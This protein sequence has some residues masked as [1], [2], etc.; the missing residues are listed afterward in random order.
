MNNKN[1]FK[2]LIV[3]Q[4]SIVLVENIYKISYNLP[5]SEKYGIASQMNR[6]AVSIP[7]NIAEGQKRG[8]SQDFNRFISI[9]R[10]SAAELETQLIIV[11]KVF[12]INVDLLLND[13][14]EIQKMLTKLH[15]SLR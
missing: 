2:D 9:A 3:W 12:K 11:N 15:Q 8:S 1:T 7:S 6:S 10:D 4:K 13:L 14:E 5:E